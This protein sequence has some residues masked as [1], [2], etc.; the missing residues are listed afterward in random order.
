MKRGVDIF[1]DSEIASLKRVIVHRPDEGILRV[2]PKQ[3]AELLFDDIVFLPDMQAEHKTFVDVLRKLVGPEGVLE[4]QD[5]LREA[6]GVDLTARE[7]MLKSLIEYEELPPSFAP[8]LGQ[9]P[10]DQLAEVLITGYDAMDDRILFDPIPN[11]LFTRDIAVTLGEYMVIT[12]AAKVARSRENYLTRFIL[13]Q[14][15]LFSSPRQSGKIIDLNILEDFPPS[16]KGEAVSMEGGDVMI[17][18]PEYVLIGISER[19]NLYAFHSLKSWLFSHRAVSNVVQINIPAERSFMHLDTIFTQV[20]HHRFVAYRPIVQDGMSSYVEV[21]RINGDKQYYATLKE[22]LWNEISNKIEFTWVGGGESPSQEREQWTDGCNLLAVKPGVAITYDRNAVT[23]KGF[24]DSGYR[25][26][27]APD[28]LRLP[29]AEVSRLEKTIIT[30]PSAELARA[31][32]GP[33][34]MSCPILRMTHA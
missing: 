32:G 14:H 26:L 12:K 18:N 11:F 4:T 21:H 10:D 28:F 30:I 20:D 22:F 31:R 7:K 27:H 33:H 25:I 19:T 24:R 6:L 5:L 16:R 13:Y 29:S 2:S 3:S 1:A 23:I 34:C 9:L 17:L 15:P 8:K